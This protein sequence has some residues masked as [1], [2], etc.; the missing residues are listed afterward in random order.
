MGKYVFYEDDELIIYNINGS[1]IERY[2]DNEN[3]SFE[4][5]EYSSDELPPDVLAELD[6]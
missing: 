4:E 1:Y 5:P 6:I 3:E 2:K